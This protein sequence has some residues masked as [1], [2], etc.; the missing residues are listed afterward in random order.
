MTVPRYSIRPLF[1]VLKLSVGHRATTKAI[2]ITQKLDH[3]IRGIMN[4]ELSKE[5]A[6]KTIEKKKEFMFANAAVHRFMNQ[7]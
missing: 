2:V 3:Y 5:E 1:D 4:K 7:K 6:L